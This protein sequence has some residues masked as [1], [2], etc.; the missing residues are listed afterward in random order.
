VKVNFPCRCGHSKIEHSPYSHNGVL[1]SLVCCTIECL[2]E[3]LDFK[4]DNLRYL[5]K[6]AEKYEY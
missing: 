1:I 2:C 3:C 6:L 4:T 5:E